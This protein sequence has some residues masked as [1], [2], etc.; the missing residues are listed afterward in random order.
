VRLGASGQWRVV[1]VLAVGY[2]P[3]GRLSSRGRAS[4]GPTGLRD[5]GTTRQTTSLSLPGPPA[6]PASKYTV[7]WG[8]S[9]G[10]SRVEEQD[11]NPM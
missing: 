9:E 1:C 3:V 4:Y 10:G 5:Y 6:S 11:S 8:A 2:C 7:G